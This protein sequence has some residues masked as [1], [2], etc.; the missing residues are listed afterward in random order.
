[1]G[2]GTCRTAN[3]VS[4]QE[5]KKNAG[6]R[7]EK[8]TPQK[9]APSFFKK[10]REPELHPSNGLQGEDVQGLQNATALQVHKG[11]KAQIR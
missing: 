3:W 4:P 2:A 9:K 10:L 1:M 7:P 8:S 5:P 11:H 6:P